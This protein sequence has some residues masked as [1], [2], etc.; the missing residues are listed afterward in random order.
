MLFSIR[1]K[2]N[3]DVVSKGSIS[4]RGANMVNLTHKGTQIA[5]Q[6]VSPLAQ[7]ERNSESDTAS[8]VLSEDPQVNNGLILREELLGSFQAE[9]W[10]CITPANWQMDQLWAGIVGIWLK[11]GGHPPLCSFCSFWGWG[12][13]TWPSPVK[14]LEF[15]K[16]WLQHQGASS[17]EKTWA[18]RTKELDCCWE[19]SNQ[20]IQRRQLRHLLIR[21]E[22]SLWLHYL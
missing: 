17:K 12:A 3:E 22:A 11:T 2:R 20:I 6:M 4:L 18:L 16:T 15:W 14:I 19:L 10:G 1:R 7:L 5:Q 9:T 13:F 21:L 8:Q